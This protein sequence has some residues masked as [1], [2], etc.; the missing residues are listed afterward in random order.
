MNFNEW[1]EGDY[2]SIKWHI[3]DIKCRDSKLSTK[4]CREILQLLDKNHD[5]S[6]G[7]NWEVIDATIYHYKTNTII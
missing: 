6:I 1:Q 3:D 2:I 7:I 4:Q 5:A